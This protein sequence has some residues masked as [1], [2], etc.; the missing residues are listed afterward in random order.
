MQD[1]GGAPLIGYQGRI[2]ERELIEIRRT[3]ALV[4]R[5]DP[6]VLEVLGQL[7]GMVVSS[8][9]I[10]GQMRWFVATL[11]LEMEGLQAER[12]AIEAGA[13]SPDGLWG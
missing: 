10:N 12:Y 11:L 6:S 9:M 2:P 8:E 4:E 7:N 1:A 5:T 3:W 13:D